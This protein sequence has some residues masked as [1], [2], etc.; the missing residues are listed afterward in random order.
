[1]SLAKF[2]DALFTQQGELWRRLLWSDLPIC[3]IPLM[4]C[5]GQGA[6]SQKWV[7]ISFFPVVILPY[8]PYKYGG[9]CPGLPLE[10]QSSKPGIN[11][12]TL[13]E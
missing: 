2:M 5:F 3:I 9:F 12:K 13:V 7:P 11:L 6:Q 8:M 4:T 1:M 10:E